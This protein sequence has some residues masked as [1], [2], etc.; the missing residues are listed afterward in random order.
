MVKNDRTAGIVRLIVLA[1]LFL[2]QGLVALG[3]NPLPFS[4]EQIFQAVSVVAAAVV[5]IWTWWMNNNLTDEALK[6]QEK[7]EE[8]KGVKK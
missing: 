2:N 7:L 1:I 3:Y 5:V 6:A 4:D 8:L